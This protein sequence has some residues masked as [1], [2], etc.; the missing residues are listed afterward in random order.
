MSIIIDNPRQGE[1][2][3]TSHNRARYL[4]Q[5]QQ[6]FVTKEGKLHILTYDWRQE[7][8]KSNPDALWWNGESKDRFAMFRPGEVRS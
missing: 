2:S 3:H 5:T 8:S 1:S 6:A 4:C 7:H